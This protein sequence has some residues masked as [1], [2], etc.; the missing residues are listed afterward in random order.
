MRAGLSSWEADLLLV[1]LKNL[2]VFFKQVAG[3]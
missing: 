2:Y 3:A 1:G